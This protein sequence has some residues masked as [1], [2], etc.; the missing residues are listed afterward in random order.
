MVCK[1]DAREKIDPIKERICRRASLEF[2]NA[3]YANLGIGW[4]IK[5]NFK[6]LILRVKIVIKIY[7]LPMLVPNYIPKSIDVFLHGIK[8]IIKF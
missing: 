2:K 4:V 3:T 6:I 8:K 5:S 7:R 1:E